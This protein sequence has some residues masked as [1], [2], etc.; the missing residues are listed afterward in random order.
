MTSASPDYER[1]LSKF[2]RRKKN[3]S[4]YPGVEAEVVAGRHTSTTRA[5]RIAERKSADLSAKQD[6]EQG[7]SR[8]RRL[9][10]LLLE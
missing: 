7:D 6:A 1:V 2:V 3:V 4:I 5:T 8:K 10:L 9:L